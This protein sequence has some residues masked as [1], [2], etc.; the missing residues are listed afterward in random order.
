[1]RFLSRAGLP[2]VWRVVV[3][4]F[5]MVAPYASAHD[6]QHL[7]CDTNVGGNVLTCIYERHRATPGPDRPGRTGYAD[8]GLYQF[9]CDSTGQDQSPTY[10]TRIC[11]AGTNPNPDDPYSFVCWTQAEQDAWM[12]ETRP[13][14]RTAREKVTVEYEFTNN[15]SVQEVALA[16]LLAPDAFGRSGFLSDDSYTSG[17]IAEYNE[18]CELNVEGGLSDWT[19]LLALIPFFE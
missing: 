11:R 19:R 3:G 12:E 18:A 16:F 6:A 14:D 7:R 4:T 9:S 8:I 5:V 15:K 1:M 2:V 10:E 17:A 13:A